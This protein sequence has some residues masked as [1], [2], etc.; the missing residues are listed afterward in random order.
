VKE[1]LKII[2]K[3]DELFFFEVTGQQNLSE[4]L[5]TND[6]TLSSKMIMI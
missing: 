4:S 1:G 6:I 3:A 5:K 2:H